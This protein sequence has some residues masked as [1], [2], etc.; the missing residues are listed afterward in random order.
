V[1]HFSFSAR[2]N[3]SV[4]AIDR[5]GCG[6]HPIVIG[7]R[8]VLDEPLRCRPVAVAG[9]EDYSTVAIRAWCRAQHVRAVI[10]ERSDQRERGAHLTG[11]KP[12]VDKDQYRD[13]NTI[14]RVIGWFEKSRRIA[15]RVEK[16]AVRNAGMVTLAMIARTA[17]GPCVAAL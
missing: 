8:C 5:R 4:V 16:L 1:P 10:A 15:N 12:Q 7:S 14:E 3:S 11:R 6:G 2:G 13:R 9:D 17:S